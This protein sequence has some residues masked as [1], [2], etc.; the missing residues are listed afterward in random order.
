MNS[1]KTIDN[2]FSKEYLDK[3]KNFISNKGWISRCIIRKKHDTIGAYAYW[4]I[5]V[6]D[7]PLFCIELKNIIE[8]KL[9]KRFLIKNSSIIGNFFTQDATFHEDGLNKNRLTYT[10]CVYLNRI[11]A[12]KIEESDGS[13]YI[14]IPNEKHIVEIESLENRAVFFPADLIHKGMSFNKNTN[15]MRCCVT[16]KLIE[17][18]D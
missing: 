14:K 7:E 13:L 1:I 10:L 17:I 4:L 5:N 8:D 15:I 9:K 16:W 2:F 3:I 12:N 18:V 6:K 11:D